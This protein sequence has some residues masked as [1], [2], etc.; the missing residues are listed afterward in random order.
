MACA[1]CGKAQA[2]RAGNSASSAI[3]F[4]TPTPTVQR[5]RVTGSVP[6][7]AQGAIK[8][9]RG[10]G[11]QGY[12]DSGDIAVLAGG[13]RTLPS[14]SGSTLYYVGVI[15]YTTIEAARV[16]SSTTGE[17]IVVRSFGQ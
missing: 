1:S 15:G 13:S 6:G 2:S 9:V 11:V 7:L 17:D 16:Q 3:V 5:V 10:D 14:G 8:Y 12:I 4:G